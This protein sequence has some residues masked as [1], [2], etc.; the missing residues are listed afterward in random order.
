MKLVKGLL[1]KI[2][3]ENSS[4]WVDKSACL[5]G[6]KL[7]ENTV[8]LYCRKKRAIQK[9]NKKPTFYYGYITSKTHQILVSQPTFTCSKSHGMKMGLRSP[10]PIQVPQ[11]I[12]GS[13][14][15]LFS[16]SISQSAE[17]LNPPFY[18]RPPYMAISL[19]IFSLNPPTLGIL[20]HQY[21]P[22]ER[23]GKHKNKLMWQNY[24]FIFRRLQN[25]VKCFFYE[26]H[27]YKQHHAE[28]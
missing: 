19:F 17:G 28:I 1:A 25:N 12:Q 11:V 5:Y 21:C 14:V 13:K 2:R 9:N 3:N 23:P 26:Q 6:L 8:L 27:F 20:F 18:R 22:N 10:P 15:P 16:I 7:V 24:F 4:Y